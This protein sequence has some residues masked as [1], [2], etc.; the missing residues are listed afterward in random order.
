M[1]IEEKVERLMEEIRKLHASNVTLSG[2]LNT[3]AEN[4]KVHLDLIEK[5]AIE[6]EAHEASINRMGRTVSMYEIIGGSGPWK[7]N[8]S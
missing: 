4:Q 6:Q 1:T 8:K 3:L 5:L 7:G 2:I